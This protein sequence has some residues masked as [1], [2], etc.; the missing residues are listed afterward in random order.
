MKAW[1]WIRNMLILVAINV[2]L[3]FTIGYTLGFLFDGIAIWISIKQCKAYDEEQKSK[4]PEKQE[5]GEKIA[6]GTTYQSKC[7]DTAYLDNNEDG[8]I[9]KKTEQ[10]QK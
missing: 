7:F 4:R 2:L 5:K 1:I 9:C 6:I 10:L 8:L 3:A